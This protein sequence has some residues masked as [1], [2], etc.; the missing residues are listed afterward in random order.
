[1][2]SFSHSQIIDLFTKLATH[3]H[4][5]SSSSHNHTHDDDNDDDGS[6]NVH[7][8]ISSLAQSL[9]HTATP[10]SSSPSVGI[11]DAALSL[12]CFKAPDLFDSSIRCLSDTIIAVFSSW[13][14]CR[15]LV[16]PEEESS[17]LRT[18][19]SCCD[20]ADL[21]GISAHVIAILGGSKSHGMQQQKLLRAVLKLAASV[22]C[23]NS[24]SASPPPLPCE[25]SGKKWKE[26][27]QK[28]TSFLPADTSPSIHETPLRL[29]L[30]S[31][32]P[33][34]LKHDMSSILQEKMGRPFLCMDKELHERTDWKS[35]IICFV[36]SPTITHLKQK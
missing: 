22:S 7:L 34:T 13:V 30:W 27:V 29:L 9:N 5:H 36:I 12:L 2:A 18:S 11:L 3:L 33:S 31:L 17:Q 15:A 6:A 20:Y 16:F 4:C 19:L 26:A 1:M 28:L 14:S 8:P 21:I 23:C 24:F 10:S 25:N 35:I 32:E